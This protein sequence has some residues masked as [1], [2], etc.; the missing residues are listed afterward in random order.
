MHRRQFV[1]AALGATGLAILGEQRVWSAPFGP[2]L[3]WQTDLKAARKLAVAEHKLLMVVFTAEWCAFCH[4]L[5]DNTISHRDLAPFVDRHFVPVMIDFDEN[6]RIAEILEVDSLPNTVI[7][8]PQADLLVQ[9]K[10]FA[11]VASF[12][13]TLQAALDKQAEIVQVRAATGR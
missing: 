11:S 3:K 6:K 13:E 7:L 5:V 10:G 4:K 1:A 12:K 9:R 2:K 8:S